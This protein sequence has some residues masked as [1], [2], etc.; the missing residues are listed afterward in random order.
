MKLVCNTRTIFFKDGTTEQESMLSVVPNKSFSY[1]IENFTS[2]LK[3]L[4]K[5]IEGE[6]MFTNLGDGRTE[7]V[8]TYR[9]I[10][11]NVFTRAILRVVILKD[12]RG[13]LTNALTILKN[14][15]EGTDIKR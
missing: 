2:P 6:Y 12:L 3:N 10:P 9:I 4:A 13:L 11:T 1:K 15:L 5:T 14:D 7:I 8:W